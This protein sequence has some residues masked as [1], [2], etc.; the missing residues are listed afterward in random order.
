M[1]EQTNAVDQTK[2]EPLDLNEIRIW[3]DYAKREKKEMG[4]EP[5][6]A[7]AL[8]DRLQQAERDRDHYCLAAEIE[9][10]EVDRQKAAAKVAARKLSNALS[11]CLKAMHH[12]APFFNRGVEATLLTDAIT[13]AQEAIVEG[14]ELDCVED[15][16]QVLSNEEIDLIANTMPGG[17]DGFLKG[18][19]WRN[20][21]RAVEGEVLSRQGR[22]IAATDAAMVGSNGAKA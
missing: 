16:A 8:L 17:L 5:D 13:A 21:A 20:F 6:A 1:T 22:R 4:M 18:W 10:R 11:R 12:A 2:P 14:I 3:A 7:I 19:G 15:A 9:A